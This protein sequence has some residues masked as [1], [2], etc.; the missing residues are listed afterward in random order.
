METVLDGGKLAELLLNAIN[1]KNW[2]LVIVVSVVLMTWVARKY[3]SR[4]I[5]ALEKPWAGVV[6]A[7]LLS[8]GGGLI[9]TLVAGAPL[10]IGLF[11]S[12]VLTALASMGTW[13]GSKALAEGA[14]FNA[15][16]KI[17]NGDDAANALGK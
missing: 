8:V 13:S 12:S 5:P 17:K 9:T 2:S 6:L 11:L 10:T 7:F 16:N 15:A 1:A 4:F 14:G 3:G